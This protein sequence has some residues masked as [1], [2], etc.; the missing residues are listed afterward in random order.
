MSKVLVAFTAAL[1]VTLLLGPLVI[2]VLH[3]LRF[4]QWVRADGPAR[5]MKKA[6]TPTMGGVIFLAGIT[7]GVAL[8]LW[9]AGR[10]LRVGWQEGLVVLGVMLCYG[11]VGLVDD[12]IKV[13]LKRPLGL[14]AREKLGAQVLV[15]A[16]LAAV[17][18]FVLGRDT[19]LVIPFSG[20]FRDGG[21]AF[22]YGWWFFLAFAVF[23]VV[24]TANAVNLTD[25]LDGLAA[26]SVAIAAAAFAF[27]ALAV[28]KTWVAVVMAAT[29]GGCTGFLAYNRYPARVFMG[30][31]GSLA[32]GGGL[33]AA[34]VVTRSEIF[35]AIIG[36]IFVVETLSVILQVISFQLFG[37]R[38][39]RMSP[40]HHHFELAGW[41]EV[42][43]VTVFWTVQLFLA[44]LGLLGIYGLG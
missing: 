10:D 22:D 15:A 5:H 43:V 21:L 23:T 41:S 39:F 40:L 9:L 36:G 37:K 2:P 32:L 30:D 18:V 38:I 19:D 1:L 28:D 33:A 24:G 16:L 42:R 17:A 4:G 35:L 20:F 11:A 29:A 34:A 7:T 3:R 44:V 6:G 25:G 27:L 8:V 12:F 14:R 26:G 13:A 31:T